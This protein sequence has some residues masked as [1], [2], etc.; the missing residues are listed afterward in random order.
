MANLLRKADM[1]HVLTEAGVEFDPEATMVQLRPLY[2]EVVARNAQQQPDDPGPEE[3]I[4]PEGQQNV[5]QQIGEQR[6]NVQ[7]HDWAAQMQREEEELERQLT[8]P[9]KKLELVKLQRELNELDSRKID[10]HVLDAMISKFDGTDVQDVS[11]WI[12]DLENVFEVFRYSERDKLVAARHLMSGYAKRFTDVVRVH[13][14]GEMKPEL[15]KEFRRAF[16]VQ[17]VLKQLRSRVIKPEETPR[18]YVIEMQYIASRADI[19][20]RDLM[21]AIID[22]LNDE[23]GTIMLFGAET[24]STFK[25]L[26]ERYEKRRRVPAAVPVS[27]PMRT[28]VAR[29]QT[30]A[31][32]KQ[33][34]ASTSASASAVDLSNIR[35]YN[36]FAFGHYQ[37]K[38][39]APR[40]P[41]NSC[42]ICHEA[43]HTRHDCPKKPKPV[44]ALT[45]AA[46]PVAAAVQPAEDW[47]DDAEAEVRRLATQLKHHNLVSV[48][49]IKQNKCTELTPLVGLFDSGSPVSCVKKSL[50]PFPVKSDKT[51][52]RFRGMG[53]KRLSMYGYIKCQFVFGEHNLTH[54]FIVLPDDQAAVPLLIGRDLLRKMNIHLCQIKPMKYNRNEL[55]DVR[56]EN[57]AHLPSDATVSALRL[58]NLNK[59]PVCSDTQKIKISEIKNKCKPDPEVNLIEDLKS[60]KD[61]FEA[62]IGVINL[63]DADD[64][65]D[66]DEIILMVSASETDEQ[67]IDIDKQLP[68][69]DA[70]ALKSI[71]FDNY[72]KTFDGNKKLNGFCMKIKLNSDVPVYSNP[73][74]LS[75]KEKIEV[76]KTIDDLLAQGIIKPSDSPYASPIVLVRKKNGELRMCVDYRALNKITIRDHFPLP[77]IEDCIEYLG[78]KTYF[79]TIDLKS[80]FHQVPMDEESV[81]LTAFVTPMG[82]YEYC[83]MPFGLTNAPPVFQRIINRVLRELIDAGKIVVYLDDINIA[84]KTLEEHRKILAEVLRLLS[85]AGL[86]INFKK[87]KF[88]YRELVYLGYCVNENGIRPNDAHLN[89]IR[90][91]AVPRSTKEVQRCVGLFSYFRRFIYNFSRIAKPL[92]QLTKKDAKFEWSNDCAKAFEELKTK[93]TEGP[94]LS[95]YD[96]KRETELHTDASSRGYGAILLRSRTMANFTQWRIIQ[97]P[98][99]SQRHDIIV[100]S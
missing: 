56:N 77:L 62:N 61:H 16:T 89:A 9:R 71:I 63:I 3:N 75:H 11:K 93:L 31:V 2:D 82:Q 99:Q 8:I 36:C 67:C 5:Q 33:T 44:E 6:Q 45:A 51:M 18:Q 53:N 50:V 24:M 84:T 59:S 25:A 43:G 73:R 96:P 55:L 97:K 15:L 20:E 17:D 52:T 78:G 26:V 34:N 94:V 35:C 60:C 28:P 12:D 85:D 58:F 29:S 64:L 19:S 57:K 22:G 90:N 46:L 83:Y 92:T 91:Y 86:K 72:I 38:C 76:Q 81:K 48:A 47:D 4:V 66:L 70:D 100:L 54:F 14:Y 37:S 98:Q 23:R 40:R 65:I 13:S 74:R 42:F 80:G 30:G 49:F 1:V 32:P 95:I 69:T 68:Q 7:Q 79:S 39:T 10:L 87:C 21:D 88:A 27:M 41:P